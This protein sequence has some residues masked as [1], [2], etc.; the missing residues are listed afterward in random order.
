[1]EVL[2]YVSCMVFGL[3]KGNPTPQSSLTIRK[4]GNPSVLGTTE[5]L[6][7]TSPSPASRASPLFL[8]SSPA[9]RHRFLRMVDLPLNESQLEINTGWW[10]QSV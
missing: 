9:S 2:I 7:E 3:C 8:S 1:M 5:I 10:F 6:D 4:P